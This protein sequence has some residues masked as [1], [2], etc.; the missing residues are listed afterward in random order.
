MDAA[1]EL[2]QHLK[3]WIA[4][5][6]VLVWTAVTINLFFVIPNVTAPTYNSLYDTL[7]WVVWL[8]VSAAMG[9]STIQSAFFAKN[10]VI[11]NDPDGPNPDKP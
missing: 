2:V 10:K 4:I 6:A 1:S 3:H 8:Y 11:S 9:M 5:F 7:T